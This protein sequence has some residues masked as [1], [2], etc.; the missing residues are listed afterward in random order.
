MLS[1]TENRVKKIDLL[2][3]VA[4]DVFEEDLGTENC[5]L[6]KTRLI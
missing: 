3:L 1:I 2:Q 4:V 5:L 6:L